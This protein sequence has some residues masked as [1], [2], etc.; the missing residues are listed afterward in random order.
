ME[1]LF[2]KNLQKTLQKSV[3]VGSNSLKMLIFF[4]L[5]SDKVCIVW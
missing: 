4:N 3:L 1:N 5:N 2:I